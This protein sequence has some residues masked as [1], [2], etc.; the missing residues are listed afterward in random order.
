MAKDFKTTDELIE[1]LNARGV[2]T[3]GATKSAIERESYYAI[4]NGYKDPF[5][6]RV[7]MEKSPDDVYLKGTRFEWIYDLFLFDRD[8]RLLSFKYL[9]RAEAIIRTAVSY[10]FSEAHRS[11]GAYLDETSFCDSN[12]YLVPKAFKGDK[13]AVHKA[14]FQRLMKMLNGK[15]LIT[16][17]SRDFVK[18]YSDKHG[19]VPLWVLVNDLTFGNIANFYQLMQKQDRQ[20]VCT[21]V[22]R[23]S[24]RNSSE[25][26]FLSEIDLLRAI[27]ILKDFRNYCAHDERLYCAKSRGAGFSE[28]IMKLMLV[29]PQDEMQD[30]FQEFAELY[31]EYHD[32]LH[33]MNLRDLMI[34]M[35]FPM[36]LL[37]EQAESKS[38]AELEA[39][40]E[41]EASEQD[42]LSIDS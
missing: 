3:D 6:D 37:D 29:L 2:I 23:V 30:F 31:G 7:A 27:S 25:F 10:V 40:T 34:A 16:P 22:A 32:R 26:K 8:L 11:Q 9:A 13:A 5:L 19:Y 20:A 41:A 4:V 36:H 12:E 33:N 14:N 21:M 24:Q 28:M 1:L 35:G 15:L 42:N 18:H 38:E 17:K 39:E